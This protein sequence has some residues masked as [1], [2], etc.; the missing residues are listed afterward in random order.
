MRKQPSLAKPSN[1]PLPLSKHDSVGG[2][3]EPSEQLRVRWH[4]LLADGA[5]RDAAPASDGA[6]R[7]LATLQTPRISKMD[8]VGVFQEPS[9]LLRGRWLAHL[10]E[11]MLASSASAEHISHD[12]TSGAARELVP[13]L[14][15]AAGSS[16]SSSPS[17]AHAEPL[18]SLTA[19]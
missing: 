2:F 10:A 7:D 1:C 11:S 9:S 6:P 15:S 13:Q 19:T 12:P 16:N 3:V 8:S 4:K 17:L 18:C 14:P 5:L